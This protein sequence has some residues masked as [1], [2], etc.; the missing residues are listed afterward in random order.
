MVN[1]NSFA[2]EEAQ[3]KESPAGTSPTV[4]SSSLLSANGVPSGI[5]GQKLIGLAHYLY[6]YYRK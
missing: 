2:I 5:Y 6:S 3:D 1:F 4:N